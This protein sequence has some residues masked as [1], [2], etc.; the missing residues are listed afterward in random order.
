MN[1]YC[2]KTNNPIYHFDSSRIYKTEEACDIGYEDYFVS[3]SL[4]CIEWPEVVEE[5]PTS[6]SVNVTIRETDPGE[7]VVS[8][9][10]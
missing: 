1:E 8:L 3:G 10:A 4:W 6:D 7:G 2:T 9:E 5:I